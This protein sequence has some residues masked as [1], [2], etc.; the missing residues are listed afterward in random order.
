MANWKEN[1]VVGIVAAVVFII[2]LIFIIKSL[3]P[4]QPEKVAPLS[5]EARKG[6]MK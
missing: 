3:I 4:K 1:K 6:V 5:E 2:A